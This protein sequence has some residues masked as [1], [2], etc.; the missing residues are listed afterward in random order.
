[1]VTHKKEMTSMTLS[2]Q[3]GIPTNHTCHEC[4]APDITLHY[5]RQIKRITENV[6]H[7]FCQLCAVAKKEV[8]YGRA[9]LFMGR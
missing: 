9:T 5:E 1:M 2:N 8:G 7:V 6:S 3:G 4:K